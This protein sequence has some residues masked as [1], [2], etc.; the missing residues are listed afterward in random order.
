[1]TEDRIRASLVPRDRVD[2][3]RHVDHWRVL[4]VDDEPAVHEISRLVL[5]DATYDGRPIELISASSA[6]EARGV[7]EHSRDI[8][9]VLLDVVMETDDAGLELVRYVR[10]Q[11]RNQDIQIVL[12][13]GQPGMA[14]EREVV[15]RYAIN[16]YFLKTEITAQ[17]LHSIVISSLRAFR[18]IRSLRGPG[19]QVDFSGDTRESASDSQLLQEI[20]SAIPNAHLQVQPEIAL[21]SNEI[22]GLELVPQ[23]ETSLGVLG[24]SR[25]LEIVAGAPLVRRNLTQWLLRQACSWAASWQSIGTTPIRVSVPLAGDVL[26]DDRVVAQIAAVTEEFQLAPKAIDLLVS[27]TVLHRSRLVDRNA[28]LAAQSPSVSVT[29]VDFG[30]GLISLPILHRLQPDRLKIHRSFVRGVASDAERAAIA[31]SIIALAHTLGIVAVA[32][33]LTT[34]VDLQFFKWEGCEIGQGDLLAPSMALPEVAE[35]LRTGRL[36]IH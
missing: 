18:Y 29:L 3:G 31:R 19:E 17:K 9:L 14:P 7:L 15:L 5:A 23:W 24:A 1:M 26:M 20:G 6:A 35:F 34:E 30:L 2:G 28:L 33:G 36:A 32:D 4:Q 21:A 10:D 12:R 25:V 8:A 11:L 27:E 16:G 13:T 22:V